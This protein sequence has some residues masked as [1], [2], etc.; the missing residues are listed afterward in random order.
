VDDK[1]AQRIG[2]ILGADYV[3]SGE[4]I[5]IDGKNILN[6][7]VLEVETAKLLYSSS[8]EIESKKEER[9]PM[10]F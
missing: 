7:Q 3:L 2:H 9:I 8:F 1:S 4:L 5:N 10:R 6:I